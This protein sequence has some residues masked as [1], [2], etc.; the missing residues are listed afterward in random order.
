MKRVRFASLL[1]AGFAGGTAAESASSQLRDVISAADYRIIA[2]AVE[3][4]AANGHSL[5]APLKGYKLSLVE[6]GDLF[7][8]HFSDPNRPEG[9]RGSSPNMPEFEVQLRKD[10]LSFVRWV[11]V[12]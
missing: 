10:D 8:V 4:M 1:L 5:H 6:E 7:V 11:G 3:G 12:R 2:A 9:I